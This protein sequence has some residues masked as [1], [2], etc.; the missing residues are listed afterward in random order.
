MSEYGVHNSRERNSIAE[1]AARGRFIS[2]RSKRL[3]AVVSLSVRDG[4]LAGLLEL[5]HGLSV[6][7]IISE[8]TWISSL[9][10]ASRMQRVRVQ[11]VRHVKE[12]E[13]VV[14]KLY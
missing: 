4:A 3:P 7:L 11:G 6:P 2:Q 5:V 13:I 10:A 1:K 12:S 9:E 8:I 14:P